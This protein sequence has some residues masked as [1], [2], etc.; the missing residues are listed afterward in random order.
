MSAYEVLKSH[1]LPMGLLP[2]GVKDFQV[3]G[4]GRF[5]VR[6]DAACTAKF[7]SQSEVRFNSTVSG[8]LSY[9]QIAALSGVAAQELFLWFPVL[10]IRVDIPSSGLIYFDV[11]VIYKR[12]SLSLFETPLDCIPLSSSS[13][14]EAQARLPSKVYLV[15]IRTRRKKK[16]E[17]ELIGL[18]DRSD[19]VMILVD[20]DCRIDRECCVT[21]SIKRIL[22]GR[23]CESKKNRIIPRFREVLWLSLGSAKLL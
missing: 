12:F 3:D 11:G 10:G 14:S 23:F 13:S 5:E 4:D 16:N 22:K 18:F 6:L 15:F 20:L 2:K 21:S 1:G 9:G 7:E 19:L 8:T 17:I